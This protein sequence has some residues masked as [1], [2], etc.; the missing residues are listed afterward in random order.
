MK[1]NAGCLNVDNGGE[2]R[3]VLGGEER[4][5]LGEERKVL[6]FESSPNHLTHF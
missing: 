3:E 5:V 2:E 4:E 6:G 1:M